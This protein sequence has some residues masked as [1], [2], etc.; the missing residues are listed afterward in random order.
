[1]IFSRKKDNTQRRPQS[2]E[3]QDDITFRRSRTLQG[4]TSP[5]VKTTRQ[6]KS[7]LASERLKKQRSHK[8]RRRLI[9]ASLL[10]VVG[11]FV[12]GQLYGQYIR[13]IT[14]LSYVPKTEQ[15]P[16]TRDYTDAIWSYFGSQPSQ[17]F[18]FMIDEKH[19]TDTVS[20]DHRE[21][22]SIQ[23]QNVSNGVAQ[24]I[25]TVRKPIASWQNGSVRSYVDDDGVSFSKNYFANPRVTIVDNS[26]IST[27]GKTVVSESFLRFLGRMV[28]LTNKSGLGEVTEASIP[29]NTTREIDIK[30]SGR[31][32]FIK[33]HTDRDPAKTVEDMKRVV[34]YLDQKKITPSYIDVRIDG[35]AYYK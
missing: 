15:S 1:M 3:L 31:P 22:K 4:T 17:R 27:D 5:I 2:S 28:A 13:D 34:T 33:T 16:P 12:A 14:E 24:F 29:Q 23:K 32:F 19:L 21:I 10:V 26:G 8:R 35:R 6:K 18:S 11:L 25:V 9:Y 30:I 7:G 20:Q